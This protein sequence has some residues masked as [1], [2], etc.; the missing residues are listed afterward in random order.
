M[1][2]VKICGL[3]DPFSIETSIYG[4]ADFIGFV[5]APTSPRHVD[6]E[7]AAYLTG[8][9]PP[10]VKTVG[11]FV[12][13]PPDV[14]A[15]ALAGVRLDMIQLHG[16]E[17]PDDVRTLKRHFQ[18]PV[19]KSLSVV[20]AQ[21]VARTKDF[22][23][24]ADWILL[25]SGTGGTGTPFDWSLLD[26]FKPAIPWMLAGGLNA[27]NVQDAIHRFSPTAVDV[28]SGVESTRGVKDPQKIKA[29]LNSVKNA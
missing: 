11:L 1:T 13:A 16:A 2:Q 17:T 8:Y 28:S 21:D 15:Q 18:K 24:V 20:G 5:F 23:T 14:I 26:G 10:H 12:D 27:E 7:V 9:I 29:F 4:G 3:T 19:I 6:L 25:D 22:E